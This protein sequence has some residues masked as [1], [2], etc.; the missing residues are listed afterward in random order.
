MD[1]G[2]VEYCTEGPF[3]IYPKKRDDYLMRRAGIKRT[4]NMAAVEA[5]ASP[6]SAGEASDE[7]REPESSAASVNG[8]G[9]A[10]TSGGAPTFDTV[11]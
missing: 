5:S 9:K 6:T 7:L 10:R 2:A 8:K 3:P 1:W 11:P 4:K